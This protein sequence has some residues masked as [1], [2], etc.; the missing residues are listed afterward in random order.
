MKK[1]VL[2]LIACSLLALTCAACGEPDGTGNSGAGNSGGGSNGSGNTGR[3]IVH[4]GDAD[5][6]QKS[7]TIEKGDTVVLVADTATM[8][9]ITSGSW[10]YGQQKP[11]IG[12]GAIYI[13]DLQIDGMG[14]ETIGPFT[15]A[16]TFKYYCSIHK[17]MNLTV[18]VQ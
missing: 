6:L 7:I 16:G 10:E 2:F 12:G 15:S 5:F 13:K 3:N 14:Q 18:I 8:H 11:I 17:N 4:M 9:S 1:W